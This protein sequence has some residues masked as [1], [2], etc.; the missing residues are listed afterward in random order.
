MNA[1]GTT[2]AITLLANTIACQYPDQTALLAIIFT[3]LGDTLATIA[4]V[5]EACQQQPDPCKESC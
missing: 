4:A 1:F 5:N 3:Q 2:Q